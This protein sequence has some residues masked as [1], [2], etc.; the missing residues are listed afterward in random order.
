MRLYEK[1]LVLVIIIV[2][3][4]RGDPYISPDNQFAI[5]GLTL[6]IVSISYLIGG[7]WLFRKAPENHKILSIIAGIA[8]CPSVY[9]LHLLIEFRINESLEVAFLPNQLLFL[10][11]GCLLLFKRKKLVEKPS[12]RGIFIRSGIVLFFTAFLYY[13]PAKYGIYRTVQSFLNSGNKSLQNNLK[14]VEYCNQFDIA[15]KKG[16]YEDALKYA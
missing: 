12:I 16:N 3:C 10:F 6:F 5:T 9:Y 13:V 2:L 15:Y 1:I 14:M 8:L 7:Y 11:I 4:L